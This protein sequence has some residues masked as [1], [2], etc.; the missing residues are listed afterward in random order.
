MRTLILLPTYNERQNV[1]ELIPRIFSLLPDAHVMVID[2]RSPDG[3]GQAV[4]GLQSDFPRLHLFER[5][6]KDGL[7]R[8]YA[9]AF[10]KVLD[11]FS[12]L[13]TIVTMDADGSH[14]PLDL[15][16]LL[17]ERQTA[18]VV[19]GSRYVAGG[20][21]DGWERARR[22]LSRWGN[23]Y[24]RAITSI[25]VQDATSGFVC[26]SAAALKQLRFSDLDPSGYAF[27]IATKYAIW[28]MGATIRE[29]PVTFKGRRFG[30]S[31]ISFRIV[32]EG[33][34]LPWRLI[35]RRPS[36]VEK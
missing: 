33:V 23:A 9:D 10:Q 13:D 34:L 17:A 19:I 35:L 29:C 28:K 14:D 11:E 12:D 8:A 3:T 21:I 1:V 2:D 18:D 4:R 32:G 31:K 6:K 25:P 30:E 24:A 22:I 27:T 5:A 7:G 26:F 36:S 20:R 16:R 15:P